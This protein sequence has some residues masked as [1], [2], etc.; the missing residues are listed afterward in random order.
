V[1]EVGYS[2]HQRETINAFKQLGHD[3]ICVVMGGTEKKEVAHF[4]HELENKSGKA[5]LIK[6]LLPG[7]I[8]NA[9]KDISLLKHD[10]KAGRQLEKAIKAHQPD[11][12]YERGEYLQDSGVVMAEK[13]GI[14]HYLEVNSPVVEEMD[15]FEGSDLLRFLGHKK[16]STKLKK[17]HK[18]FAVSS[19]IMQYLI[20]RYN[21]NKEITIIPNC[22]NPDAWSVED[23]LTNSSQETASGKFTV[24]FVGSLFPYHGVHLL[25]EAFA[26]FIKAN[27][28]AR[29][30]VVGDGAIKEALLKQAESSLPESSFLFTGKV[31]HKEAL[32][33]IKSFN[34]AVMPASNW[35][36]S[37]VKIFEYGLLG[38]PI[39]APDNGPVRDVMN[40]DVDGFLVNPDAKDIAEKLEFVYCN[41][42]EAYKR[43]VCFRDK[44]LGQY[45]WKK[46]AETILRDLD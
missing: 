35:Y 23:E 19:A 39:V 21:C 7:F 6:K 41:Q 9:L 4:H 2:T 11:L 24:G 32:R 18:V 8:W 12:I 20:N 15:A 5:G 36:G 13:Y 30:I 17:T 34:V 28:N 27:A 1:S 25:I 40:P 37:P 33:Y 10:K 22:I 43:A 3:V 29:L 42:E 31:P 44:I 26:I 45:T 46:Q 38:K 14:R 16:E